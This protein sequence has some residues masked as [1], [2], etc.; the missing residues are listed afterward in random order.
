[1]WEIYNNILLEDSIECATFHLDGTNMT[2][3]FITEVI[4]NLTISQGIVVVDNVRECSWFDHI[5]TGDYRLITEVLYYLIYN[6]ID[7]TSI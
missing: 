7:S 5:I 1:M 3:Y 6:W 4:L 2:H